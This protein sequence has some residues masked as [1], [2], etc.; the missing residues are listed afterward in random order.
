MKRLQVLLFDGVAKSH[1]FARKEPEEAVSFDRLGNA[2]ESLRLDEVEV[3]GREEYARS[4]ED[5]GR[6]IS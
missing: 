3:I 4:I 6:A 2:R 1:Q 5:E